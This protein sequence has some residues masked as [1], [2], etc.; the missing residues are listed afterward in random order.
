MF[1]FDSRQI[2]ETKIKNKLYIQQI[3]LYLFVS[4]TIDR[5]VVAITITTIITVTS[6]T[7]IVEIKRETLSTLWSIQTY[8]KPRLFNK[9]LTKKAQF[10][11]SSLTSRS[12][13]SSGKS[14]LRYI[15]SLAQAVKRLVHGELDV[16][17]N[18]ISP[19]P[20][21]K[22]SGKSILFFC[23]IVIS[24]VLDPSY[25]SPTLKSY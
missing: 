23:E 14:Q 12:K 19:G 15:T 7:S 8:P 10:L 18:T 22:I 9:S 1:K 17:P 13:V 5:L 4:A 3:F 16:P 2:R 11:L 24:Q 20:R 6:I 21:F 25:W